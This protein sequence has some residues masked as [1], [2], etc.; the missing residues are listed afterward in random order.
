M[1]LQLFLTGLLAASATADSLQDDAEARGPLAV[2]TEF[3]DA[4]RACG[5]IPAYEP[6][7]RMQTTSQIIA[8]HGDPRAVLVS[9]WSEL[10]DPVQGLMATWAA[11]TA[12]DETP[13]AF[14][15]TMFQDMGVAH[16][17]GHWLQNQSGRYQTLS[18]W[19]TEL[20]A[21]RIGIAF[22]ERRDG[23]ASVARRIERFGWLMTVPYA[24]PADRDRID[25]F[26]TDYAA[27]SRDPVG[28]GWY[29]AA[30]ARAA[31]E[32]HGEDDFCDL[33]RLNAPPAPTAS[34]G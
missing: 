5:V 30:L 3:L 29:Q 31:W 14:F 2:R 9:R 11:N 24:P 7:L 16:E 34:P 28:Y 4:V 20:E 26:N 33:V 1:W 8:Y 6:D 10:P 27:L 17:L 32:D 19:D 12:P 25:Y 23:H 18:R 22:A 13:Q 15:Q 21:N